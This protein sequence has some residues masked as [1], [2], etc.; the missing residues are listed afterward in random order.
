VRHTV[1][2]LDGFKVPRKSGRAGVPRHPRTGHRRDVAPRPVRGR[3][4][5]ATCSVSSAPG[6]SR[7]GTR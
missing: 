4:A 3:P 1:A 5:R 7:V 2:A 6:A